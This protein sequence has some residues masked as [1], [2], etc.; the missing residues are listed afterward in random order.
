MSFSTIGVMGA[1]QP[2]IDFLYKKLTHCSEQKL[3]GVVFYEG[4]LE[5]KKIILCCAGMG[6]AAA[7]AATQLLCTSFHCE[8][9]LFSGIAGNMTS[10]IGV[11][12]VVIG[13]TAVYHDAERRMIAQAYPNLQEYA[14]DEKMIAV[15][16]QICR[17]Q[18]VHYIVGKI[19]T[20]DTFVGD[21]ATKN[22]IAEKVNPH[23]VEMEG[24][25]VAHIAAKNDVPCLI[26][27]A[28]SDDA[29][30]DAFETLAH[31]DFDITEYCTTAAQI[32]EAI[33]RKLV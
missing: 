29:N 8:A 33:L 20:G 17:E 7:A 12:D 23:C 9:I 1:M 19:A 11:G 15:A 13:K 14:C 21:T 6:K 22:A 18:G 3:G 31:K 30:E 26:L 25:A 5:D 2:E 32:C 4:E 28:M 27:R 16:E 24:A 10:S